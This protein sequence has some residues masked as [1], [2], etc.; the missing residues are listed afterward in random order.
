MFTEILNNGEAFCTQMNPVLTA[1][2]IRMYKKLQGERK[3]IC[4]SVSLRGT[5]TKGGSIHVWAGKTEAPLIKGDQRNLT[6]YGLPFIQRD[7]FFLSKT[8]PD[9]MLL[10]YL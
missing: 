6:P 7:C 2:I 3:G 1:V 8:I 9:P 4:R 5:P 10:E